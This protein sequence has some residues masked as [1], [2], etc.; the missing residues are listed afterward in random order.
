VFG[1]KRR[2]LEAANADLQAVEEDR[3]SVLVSLLAEVARNYVELR[4]TQRRLTIA[5]ENLQA[6]EE[7][8]QITQQRFN[9]GLVS[10]LDVAQAR[11]VLASTRSQVPSLQ[12]SEKQSM[13]TLSVLLGQP[14]PALQLELEKEKPIPPTPPE[15]PAGLPSD[16]LQRRPDVRRSERQLAAA[17]ARIGVAVAEF[18]PKFSLTGTAGFQSLETGNL[19]SP[20]SEFWTAGPTVRWRLLEYPRLRAQV[21]A[22]TAEQE[23]AL[24]LFE[25]AVLT[26][27]ADVENALVAYGKE[28]ERY[29]ALNDEVDANRLALDLANQIY[30]QGRGEFLNVLDAE[31]SLYQSEDALAQ[32]RLTVTLDL[33]ALYKA[34]GG[35]WQSEQKSK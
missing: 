12:S 4:G 13:H 31:R 32:S 30:T 24:A 29:L 33:V 18:F 17:N 19:F 34:L 27:L 26:A 6:Q 35:G 9:A 22:Q 15:V 23:Q 10:Q 8:L 20:A 1:G 2:A 7:A 25:Q 14:P 16:L 5:G 3:R 21:L 28:K 11:A